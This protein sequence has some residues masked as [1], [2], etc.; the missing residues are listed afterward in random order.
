M[1][2]F[3]LLISKNPKT[4]FFL[5]SVKKM[6]YDSFIKAVKKVVKKEERR[7]QRFRQMKKESIQRRRAAKAA[8]QAT[9]KATAQAVPVAQ[10]AKKR[11][12]PLV[13]DLAKAVESVVDATQAL[14]M[15]T[16]TAEALATSP[17]E[18]QEEA[19]ATESGSDSDSFQEKKNQYQ[20]VKEAYCR[21]NDIDSDD[22]A[23]GE[24]L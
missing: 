17:Q 3:L 7:R 23:F 15:H 19:T 10:V 13:E 11:V 14:V 20:A 4:N 16:L 22:S 1:H 6:S 21:M 9:A 2:F 8:A 12:F 24:W 5:F 18:S